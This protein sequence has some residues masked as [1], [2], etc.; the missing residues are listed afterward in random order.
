MPI[1][2]MSL[3]GSL[4]NNVRCLSYKPLEKNKTK[5]ISSIQQESVFKKQ[6][7]E[8]MEI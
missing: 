3:S 7:H 1:E 8:S 6:K 4:S 2:H 5:K